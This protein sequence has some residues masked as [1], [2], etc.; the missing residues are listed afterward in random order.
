MTETRVSDCC[1]AGLTVAGRTTRYY[2]CQQCGKPCDARPA[3]MLRP[4]TFS[5]GD[6]PA[7][8]ARFREISDEEEA[9]DVW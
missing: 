5:T 8:R 7:R 3:S 9:E 4:V 1:G 2:V 6:E